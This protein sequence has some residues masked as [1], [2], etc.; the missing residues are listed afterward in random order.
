MK[1]LALVFLLLLFAASLW[2]ATD[3]PLIAPT[4]WRVTL[5]STGNTHVWLLAG[6]NDTLSVLF[7]G[8]F[9]DSTTQVSLLSWNGTNL[10]YIDGNEDTVV[11]QDQSQD[12][13]KWVINN[14]TTSV[15]YWQ[16]DTIKVLA[17]TG[18]VRWAPDTGVVFTV[19]ADTLGYPDSS[20]YVTIAGLLQTMI[21]TGGARV[22]LPWDT[23]E[24]AMPSDGDVYSWSTD[25]FELQAQSGG[26]GSGLRLK[27]GGT[28]TVDTIAVFADTQGISWAVV[29]TGDTDIDTVIL[30][31]AYVDSSVVAGHATTA[32]SADEAAHAYDADSAG[33]AASAYVADSS[34]EAAHAY[35][36]DSAGVAASAY[37]ADSADEAAHAYDADSAGVAASAYVADSADEAAHAYDADSAGVA[38]SAHV[39][40]SADEAAHAYDADSAGVAASAYVADSSDEAAHAYD[41]DSA[42]VAASAYVADSSDEAAHAYDADS[43][44]VAASAYVADSSDET[45]H[46][47]D[48][49]SAGIAAS[50]YVADSSDE[51][52]H[53]YDA[54]SAGVAASAYVADSADAIDTSYA[55][56]QQLI[57]DSVTNFLR[58]T[59]GTMSGNIAM[60]TNDVTG[61][62]ALA[63]DSVDADHAEIA[64]NVTTDSVDAQ[65]VEADVSIGGDSIETVHAN[66][67]G[68]LLIPESNTDPAGKNELMIDSTDGQL[69]WNDGGNENILTFRKTICMTVWNPE[70]LGAAD[71]L[72]IFRVDSTVFP[73]GA[74]A[75]RVILTTD[76]ASNYNIDVVRHTAADPPGSAAAV[77][78]NHAT[79]SE[80]VAVDDTPNN[81][82]IVPGGLISIVFDSDDIVWVQVCIV[83]RAAD[84]GNG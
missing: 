9:A 35:D 18:Y 38:A 63:G 42:G 25:H 48:A 75:E 83:L 22:Y 13:A 31:I 40:D 80:R 82:W 79:S 57:Q 24:T 28:L 32:D 8:I 21:D 12:T 77:F 46:A 56:L 39:A 2:G 43:A 53:A 52:A 59:G 76:A 23:L 61:A 51:A 47:Y 37:V 50:A 16:G 70:D 81:E 6:E 14:D 84:D 27:G 49:D 17:N 74:I 4:F 41:A 72:P 78:E 36:A 5:D 33:V 1:K 71:T 7:E 44:G 73:N 11:L 55:P 10:W 30:Q 64:V 54:D 15:W 60:G 26:G 68:E 20:G 34:D 58:K 65:H 19:L 67:T 3:A 62:G 29:T 66:F 45:A 69:I